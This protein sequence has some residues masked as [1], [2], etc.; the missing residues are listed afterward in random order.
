MYIQQG[1]VNSK[2]RKITHVLCTTSTF[3]YTSEYRL[4][5]NEYQIH[6]EE[7][8]VV[9]KWIYFSSQNWNLINIRIEKTLEVKLSWNCAAYISTIRD[10]KSGKSTDSARAS[11]STLSG[12]V[13]WS[14]TGCRWMTIRMRHNPVWPWY[15]TVDG[16][17][18][19][20]QGRIIPSRT[21]RTNFRNVFTSFPG[22]VSYWTRAK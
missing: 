4:H 13:R 3:L 15:T 2:H 7:W 14:K 20:Y 10:M 21:I 9:D 1:Q 11:G 18:D 22:L 17:V 8:W 5:Q 6:G 16:G 19:R 12:Y